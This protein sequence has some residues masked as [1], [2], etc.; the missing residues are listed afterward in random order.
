V[1]GLT[2]DDPYT[3]NPSQKLADYLANPVEEAIWHMVNADPA[4]TPTLA[5]FANPDYYLE[6]GKLHGLR[7]GRVRHAG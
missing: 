3:G 4:R 5:M 1:A 2:A 6:T 7:P